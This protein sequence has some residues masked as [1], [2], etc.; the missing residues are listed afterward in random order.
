MP[1]TAEPALILLRP[2]ALPPLS[3]LLVAAA[4]ELARWHDRRHTRRGLQHLDDRLLSDIG[5]TASAAADE[6]RK[7]FWRD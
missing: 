2:A 4:V 3:R 5:L 7:P 6:L 1:R